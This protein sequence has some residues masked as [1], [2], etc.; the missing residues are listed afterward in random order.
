MVSGE[1]Q[2]YS[3]STEISA[4]AMKRASDIC[5]TI[6]SGPSSGIFAAPSRTNR[7]LYVAQNPSDHFAFAD[8]VALL[9]R[10]DDFARKV[11]PRIQQVTLSLSADW[12]EIEILRA[13]G[14]AYRDS[15]PLVRFSVTVMAR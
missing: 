13:G 12:Q 7:Q 5:R 3:H 11:D 2:G 10:V 6:I 14:E 9:Q 1:T 8:K 15:R 4:A